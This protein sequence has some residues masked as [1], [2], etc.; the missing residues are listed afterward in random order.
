MAA[1]VTSKTAHS[2]WLKALAMEARRDGIR[3]LDARPGH[4]ETGLATRAVAG[5]APSF[6]SG[7][8][9]QHVVSVIVRAIEDGT[10]DLPSEAF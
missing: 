5:V 8:T 10:K 1:Y 9:A 4:T 3:I 6:P 2:T 7:M